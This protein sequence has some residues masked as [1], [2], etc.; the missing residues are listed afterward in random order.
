MTIEQKLFS[1]LAPLAEKRVYPDVSP[2]TLNLPFIVYQQVGGEA[3]QYVDDTLPEKRHS[4]FQIEVWAETRAQATTIARQIEE[5]LV[6][7]HINCEVYGALTAIYDD[8]VRVYGTRQDFG[9][10][11]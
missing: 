8:D 7:A 3:V 5:T 11:F 1:L 2:E 9:F 10:Y 4:R 6:T